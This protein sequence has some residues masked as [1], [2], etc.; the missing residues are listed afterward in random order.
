MFH[1]CWG[2]GIYHADKIIDPDGPAAICPACGHRHPFRRLPL[3]LIG[4]A[5]GAGKSSVCQAL[6]GRL[7]EF[8]LL[9]A[10]I[11]WQPAFD[12]PGDGY[13]AFFTTWLRLCL[14]I[15]QSGRP[16]AL[17]GAGIGVPD[18]LE[19]LVERRF[20][21]TLHYL[22]LTCDDDVLVTRLAERP[23]WRG[24]HDPAFQSAQVAFNR[25]YRVEGP[26]AT[27]PVHVL[28]TTNRSVAETAEAV[29]SWLRAKAA[30]G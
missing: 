17:F 6:L 13:R 3:L 28:D 2:C 8:V 21:S 24:T 30:S 26:G 4:G 5:S 10:D 23:A 12:T 18:A 25:W 22:A 20:F 15:G 7:P 14:N 19:P 29:A 1:V 16:V 9:D 27:P 11:I